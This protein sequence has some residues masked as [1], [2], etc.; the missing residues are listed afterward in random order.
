MS[1]LPVLLYVETVPVGVAYAVKLAISVLA[2]DEL[3]DEVVE[4]LVVEFTIPAL[5]PTKPMAASSPKKTCFRLILT[6]LFIVSP[7]SF[8]G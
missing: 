5:H 2:D 3:D 6:L 4:L 1:T 8:P 7:L